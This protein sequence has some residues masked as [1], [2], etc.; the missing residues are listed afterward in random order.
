MAAAA[1]K[2]TLTST[3]GYLL[4]M[5]VLD[6]DYVFSVIHPWEGNTCFIP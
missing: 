5:S 1:H 3:G 6:D 2:G 4:V